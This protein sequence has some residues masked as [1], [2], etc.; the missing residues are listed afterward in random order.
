MASHQEPN[1]PLSC[2]DWAN[3]QRSVRH[4]DPVWS[5]PQ[6]S[7]AMMHAEV[8][9][10]HRSPPPVL[11]PV[12]RAWYPQL[13][14]S[15]SGALSEIARRLAGCAGVVVLGLGHDSSDPDASPVGNTPWTHIEA[16]MA[17]GRGLP[18]LL[19][20]EPGVDT[21][22]FDDSVDGYRAHVVDLGDRWDEEAVR[23][24]MAPWVFEVLG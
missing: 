4:L 17:Y 20:R 6:S 13:A 21:G 22:A 16:G 3:D 7:D 8:A 18:L 24:A 5:P 15:P 12:Q 11:G 14:P 1:L 2:Q 23:T 9:R 10:A 19:L